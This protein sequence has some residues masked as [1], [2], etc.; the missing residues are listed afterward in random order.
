ME[1]LRGIGEIG[2]LQQVAIRR[3]GVQGLAAGYQT[4]QRI[5][6]AVGWTTECDGGETQ[7]RILEVVQI[8]IRLNISK[9]NSQPAMPIYE[10]TI[11]LRIFS[12]KVNS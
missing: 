7:T 12:I 2:A 9:N 4:V 1:R 11:R 10:M 5:S 8:P 6:V 3:V